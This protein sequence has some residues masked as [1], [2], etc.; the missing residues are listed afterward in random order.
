METLQSRSWFRKLCLFHKIINDQPPSYLFDYIISTYRIWTRNPA[1]VPRMKS[2]HTFFK[3]SYILST[4]TEWNKLDQDIRNAVSYALFRKHLSSFIWPVA[5]NISNGN[6]AKKVKLLTRLRVDFSHLKKHKFRHN[7]QNAINPYVAVETLLNQQ[8]TF[9]FTTLTFLM[10]DRLL[11]TK[12]K[13]LT[14]VFSKKTRL[15]HNQNSS[16]WRQETFHNRWQIY[17]SSHNSL[18]NNFRKIWLTV[19]LVTRYFI[20]TLQL[21][22]LNWHSLLPRISR[23]IIQIFHFIIPRY[24]VFFFSL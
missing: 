10:K 21:I 9:F 11:L 17:I 15:P 12:P 22:V 5:N 4:I 8:H 7:F 20:F 3:K 19:V 14:N 1:D 6:N 13:I 16:F 18:F 24:F 23:I 2:R